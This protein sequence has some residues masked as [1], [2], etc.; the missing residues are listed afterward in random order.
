MVFLWK[1]IF[2]ISLGFLEMRVSTNCF[3]KYSGNVSIKVYQKY[4]FHIIKANDY[5]MFE[6]WS[7][8]STYSI[9]I[10]VYFISCAMQNR[11][12]SVFPRSNSIIFK[13]CRDH[14]PA[15]VHP[16]QIDMS[17]ASIR[18]H[19]KCRSERIELIDFLM[20]VKTKVGD[21]KQRDWKYQLNICRYGYS[22]SWDWIT[23]QI[24]CYLCLKLPSYFLKFETVLN[25]WHT[26]Q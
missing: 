3:I 26:S 2:S 24:A 19:I 4:M 14:H 18:V 7:F 11:P 6:L 23:F 9:F 1:F 20:G 22:L 8:T 15:N 13:I 21:W 5:N 25:L 10:C 17:D 12:S 16:Q